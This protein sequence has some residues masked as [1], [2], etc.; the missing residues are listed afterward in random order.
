MKGSVTLRRA[1]LQTDGTVVTAESL[2]EIAQETAIPFDIRAG[3]QVIGQLTRIWV[4][5]G[6]LRGEAEFYDGAQPP[7]SR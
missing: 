5:D 6:E 4:V 3:D 2:E 1:G 7:A